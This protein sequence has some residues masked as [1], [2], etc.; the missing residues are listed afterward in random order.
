MSTHPITRAHPRP[1]AH[2]AQLVAQR[3]GPLDQPAPHIFDAAPMRPVSVAI[4]EGVGML[5][6]GIGGGEGEGD[7]E[8]GE[9]GEAG[10]GVL[11][12]F[13]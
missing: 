8:A 11:R 12:R 6:G 5:L 9:A 3:T 4:Q 13:W 1:P 10:K 7:S 2:I